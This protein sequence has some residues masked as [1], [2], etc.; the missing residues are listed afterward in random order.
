MQ[1][2]GKIFTAL[3]AAA[4]SACS[5]SASSAALQ[6][7]D[8]SFIGGCWEQ[9]DAGDADFLR[10]LRDQDNPGGFVG[11]QSKVRNGEPSFTNSWVFAPGGTGAEWASTTG[12]ADMLMTF[13]PAPDLSAE[14]RTFPPGASAAFFWARPGQ[15]YLKIVREGDMLV[16]SVHPAKGS[17]ERYAATQ[18][19]YFAGRL[20]G[21]D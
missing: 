5:T 7:Q 18:N 13:T 12:M 21:C 20:S 2:A 19:V 3:T 9:H 1:D 16:M 6:G 8:I 4:L 10:L 17:H 11:D 15:L 14:D